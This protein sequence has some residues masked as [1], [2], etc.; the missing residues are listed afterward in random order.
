MPGSPRDERDLSLIGQTGSS[1]KRSRGVDYPIV[2]IPTTEINRKS[3]DDNKKDHSTIGKT[4][5]SRVQ[6]SLAKKTQLTVY[7][8]ESDCNPD[9]TLKDAEDCKDT[10]WVNSSP[11]LTPPPFSEQAHEETDDENA[12]QRARK[13]ARVRG[14][15]AW[16]GE[17][18]E[19]SDDEDDDDATK[20]FWAVRAKEGVKRPRKKSRATRD[21]RL[22]CTKDARIVRGQKGQLE[23]RAGH[24][25]QACLA[26]KVQKANAFFTG[27]VTSL[28]KHLSR[29]HYAKSVEA[30]AHPP[31][32]WKPKKPVQT[33]LDSFAVVKQ[34][35]PLPVTKAGLTEYLLELIVDVNLPFQFVDSPA[36]R[37]M[38]CY[39]N[40]KLTD[41]DIPKK[42]CMAN[43]VDEKIAKL[44]GID[45]ELI[46]KFSFGDKLGWIVCDNVSINDVGVSY[47]CTEINANT[48]GPKEAR[49]RCIEHTFHLMACHF[50]K[51]LKIPALATNRR[52]IHQ[53]ASS[54]DDGTGNGDD[55]DFDVDTSME[56]EAAEDDVL[57]I[58]EASNP[59]FDAGDVVGKLMAFI[60]QL[61]SCDEDVRAY[62]KMICTSQGCPPWDIRLWVRTRW[63]SLSDCFHVFLCQ[64]KAINAFCFLAD[65]KCGIPPLQSDGKAWSD[66][67]LTEPEWRIIELAYNCLK[68]NRKVIAEMHGELSAFKTP[69]IHKVFPLL[70]KLQ[71]DWK[72][73]LIDDEYE[74]VH[75]AIEA[76]LKNVQK[77]YKETNDTSMYFISHVL[78]PTRKRRY[79]DAAWEPEW[80]ERGMKRLRAIFLKYQELYHALNGTEQKKVTDSY[81]YRDG[82]LEAVNEA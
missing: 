36:F 69:T 76:G 45:L 73:L 26:A 11:D 47:A 72:D 59:M 27:N 74:P 43:A 64:R 22:F 8:V 3:N 67:T 25:C 63:R 14:S 54:E 13:R 42:A 44:D 58:R 7:T 41:K 32:G 80:I 19:G 24:Y 71:S 28:R 18:S 66:Y 17:G 33:L 48:L 70:E 9:G 61:R 60:A 53:D 2:P 57:A 82:R 16:D 30:K 52:P 51:A 23:E 55:D 6:S 81:T 77:W 34:K 62:L 21:I 49:G 50:I 12:A 31:S 56:V 20:R 38:V 37:R 15:E 78:D 35:S 10:D 65:S 4:S 29:H 79:L 5:S 68:C 1:F 46:A 40:P 39:L 75:H